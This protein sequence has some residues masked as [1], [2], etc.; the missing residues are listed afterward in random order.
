MSSIS[1]T[2]F[3]TSKSQQLKRRRNFT[4][5]KTTASKDPDAV[6]AAQILSTPPPTKKRAKVLMPVH[7]NPDNSDNDE[8]PLT[9]GNEE[10]S[11]VEDHDIAEIL[12]MS[13]DSINNGVNKSTPKVKKTK[14]YAEVLRT[15][16]NHHDNYKEK[17]EEQDNLIKQQKE[18]I[19]LLQ[20]R[21]TELE[22]TMQARASGPVVE[23]I[24][25]ELA[26][27][28]R[29]IFKCKASTGKE[30]WNFNLRFDAKENV[31]ITE[32]FC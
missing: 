15:I 17:F 8:V 27:K 28:V 11:N 10:I 24:A 23:P 3:Y 26:D 20:D 5:K 1:K 19:Q 13:T 14:K 7:N 32:L 30:V 4:K 22:G 25:P 9:N 12:Q 31:H 18:A 6:F 16:K 29:S 2:Q 21:V